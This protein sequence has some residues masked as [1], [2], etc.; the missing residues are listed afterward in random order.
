[1][2]RIPPNEDVKDGGKPPATIYRQ[3]IAQNQHYQKMQR[4]A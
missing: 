2:I 4:G 3:R 1:M